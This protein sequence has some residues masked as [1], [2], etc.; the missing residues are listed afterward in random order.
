MTTLMHGRWRYALPPI[1]VALAFGLTILIGVTIPQIPAVVAFNV[2]LFHAINGL[3]CGVTG[4][5][6]VFWLMWTGMN[7]PLNNYVLLY[8]IGAAYVL[9]RRRDEWPK[10]IIVGLVIAAL[11]FVSNPIIWQWAWG[12][13]PFTMTDACIL[14]P[15][16]KDRWNEYSS[17]PSGHARETAAEITLIA[18]FWRRFLPFGLLYLLLLAFSRLYIGVHFPLDVTVGAILGWA[19]ARISFLAYHV[20]AAPLI[21]RRRK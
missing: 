4:D 17:F 15:E 3:S 8:A 21:E 19:I 14:Y 1:L 9:L 20:Y 13:R 2:A 7:Q 5:N 6:P 18:T 12:P 10:L 16:W 11:G